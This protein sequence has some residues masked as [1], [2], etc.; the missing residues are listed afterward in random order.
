MTCTLGSR[1]LCASTVTGL[2]FKMRA[3]AAYASQRFKRK[4]PVLG[5]SEVKRQEKLQRGSWDIPGG[6]LDSLS[7]SYIEYAI[8][9]KFKM[10]L[11]RDQSDLQAV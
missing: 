10:K 9:I 2:C 5:Q 1:G 11:Q 6:F 4:R 3:Q 7:V 8:P